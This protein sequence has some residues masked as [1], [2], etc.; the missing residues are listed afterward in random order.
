MFIYNDRPGVLADITQILAS[1]GINIEDLRSPHNT[2]KQR[3]I[4]IVKTNSSVSKDVIE[5]IN[6]KIDGEV[7]FQ[8]KL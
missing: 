8:V 2:E 1:E 4:A 5:K 7:A 3:S 6:A